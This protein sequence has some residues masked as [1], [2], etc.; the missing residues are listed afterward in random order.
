MRTALQSIWLRRPVFLLAVLL[1]AWLFLDAWLPGFSWVGIFLVLGVVGLAGGVRAGV[2]AC[3]LGVG[4]ICFSRWEEDTREREEEVF[5]GLGL[6]LVEAKLLGDVVGGDGRWSAVARLYGNDCGGQKVKWRGGGEVPVAGTHLRAFG[7]FHPLEEERN[8]GLVDRAERLRNEGVVAVFRASEMREERWIGSFSEWA[9]NFREGFRNGI[10]TGLDPESRAAKVIRA[11]VIGE[12]SGDSLELVRDFR[13]SGTLH[14]FTVSGMHVMMVG[15]LVWFALKW[16][17]VPR[18]WAVPLIVGTMFGYAWIAGSGPAA[19]RAA[20]MS[21]VFL[22]A[23][24]L[25]RRPDLLNSLGVVL[26]VSLIWNPLMLKMPGVQLSYGVVAAIG[27]L[28]VLVRRFFVWI[29]KEEEFLPVSEQGHVRRRWLKFRRGLAE[30]LAVSMAAWIGSAPL[31]MFHFKLITPVSVIATVVLVAQVYVLLPVA[32]VSTMFY[33]VVPGFSAVLNRGNACV[34]RSCAGTAGFFASLPGA[35]IPAGFP[36]KDSLLIYDLDYGAAAACFTSTTGNAVLI[37]TGGDFNLES[38]V[39]ISLRNLGIRPDSV[40]FTHADAGHVVDAE[41]LTGMFEVRQLVAAGSLVSDWE[42]FSRKGMNVVK[43]VVGDVLDFGGGVTG[44]VLFSPFS[45][46]G[47]SLADDRS[48]VFRMDWH[49]WKILWLGDGGRMI[50]ERMLASG[51]DLSADVIV[52]GCHESDLSL[53][54]DFVK[55]VNP[56][57]IVIPQAPGS[58]MDPYRE[59]LRK[60]WER[61]GVVTIDQKVTGG[62]TVKAGEGEIVFEGFVD[63]SRM[64]FER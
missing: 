55:A 8:P 49:G 15:S 59:G 18:R 2:S 45:H 51:K 44:E 43:P 14:V 5:A 47:G 42:G 40:I 23:F 60:R 53:T 10:L 50:E 3:L 33:P 58:E 4:L 13:H 16:V 30:A 28:T 35:W 57:V 41:L 64:V 26:L 17:G 19:M 21:S 27:L 56:R 52:A 62:L 7:T 61:K 37:D 24:S 22:A 46:G 39:G 32:L 34:A 1:V 20:W 54:E 12:R 6:R 9:A 29:A 48:L 36:E 25:R 63:G 11:A 31:S 38:Q